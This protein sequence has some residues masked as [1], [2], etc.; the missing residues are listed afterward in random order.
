MILLVLLKSF[1]DGERPY[2]TL[3]AKP[4][5]AVTAR[6]WPALLTQLPMSVGYV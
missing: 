2:L 3:T 1:C 6:F 4:I 5:S